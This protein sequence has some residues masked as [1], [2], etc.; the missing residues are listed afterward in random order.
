MYI[1]ILAVSN[2]FALCLL[3]IASSIFLVSQFKEDNG[4]MDVAYGP[5]FFLAGLP[6][7]LIHTPQS[8]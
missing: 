6:Y 1:P 2:V 5:S 8:R 7:F 3:I 4:I